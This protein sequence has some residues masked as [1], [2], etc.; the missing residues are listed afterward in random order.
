MRLYVVFLLLLEA[1]GSVS[2]G[3]VEHAGIY[4]NWVKSGQKEE[5]YALPYIGGGQVMAQWAD[6]EPREDEYD[7]SAIDV[8]MQWFAERGLAATVQINGGK[9]P[10]WL[11]DR[12]PYYPQKLSHQIRDDQGSLMFWYP[13]HRDSY[14]NLLKAFAAHLDTVSYRDHILGIRLNYNPF[15]TEHTAPKIEADISLSQWIMPAG[16]DQEL[17]EEYSRSVVE[18]Y[19]RA[20]LEE[21]VHS[22]GGKIRIFVRNNISEELL[23]PYIS[24]F[25]NGTLS[26]YHTSSEVEPRY[27]SAETKYGLFYQYC[28]NGGATAYAEPWA[29]AWGHHTTITDDRWCSPPQWNYW[30][31]LFDLHCGVSFIA[32]YGKD[33]GVAINGKYHYLDVNYSDGSTGHYQEEFEQAFQFAAK[34]AGYH[35]SPETSPGAWIAFRGNSTVLA[36]NNYSVEKRAL[37]VFTNDYTFLMKR[38][39]GDLSKGEGITNMGPDDRRFGAW[40]RRL[41]SGES[42]CVEADAAF[43]ASLNGAHINVIYLDDHVGGFSVHVAGEKF[44]VKMSGSG[45]WKVEA[46]KMDSAGFSLWCQNPRITVRAGTAPVF[47]H[48]IEVTR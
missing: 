48:M 37:K 23:T 1:A 28:R 2:A 40:A 11:Y 15:G 5:I 7:F 16:V 25:E 33:L 35:A 9:K 45:E 21:Y 44:P 13:L 31:I 46:V 42:L 27:G 39:P 18:Q 4:P 22:F 17:V 19:L 24:Q 32:V 41:P 34:Y 10:Q 47:L 26:W 20:V 30:R 29:S 14:I 6:L 38:L 8:Q 43:A 3:R 12:V 36:A